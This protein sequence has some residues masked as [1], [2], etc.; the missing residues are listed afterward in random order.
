MKTLVYCRNKSMLNGFK[1]GHKF[2]GVLA[3]YTQGVDKR[4]YW[5]LIEDD[6]DDDNQTYELTVKHSLVYTE[7]GVEI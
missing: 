6:V 7:T 4:G 2:G 3:N 1:A 5:L